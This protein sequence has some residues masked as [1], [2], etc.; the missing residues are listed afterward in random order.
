MARQYDVL[1]Q[2][3]PTM[4]VGWPNGARSAKCGPDQVN[5]GAAAASAEA[6]A[7]RAA[8]PAS[9]AAAARPASSPSLVRRPRSLIKSMTLLPPPGIRALILPGQS[10]VRVTGTLR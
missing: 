3:T 4:F 10:R 2:D 7:G 9:A 5:R 1:G 8:A 6:G